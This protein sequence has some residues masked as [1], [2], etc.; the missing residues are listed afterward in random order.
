MGANNEARLALLVALLA[1]TSAASVAL[2]AYQ[3]SPQASTTTTTTTKITITNYN[4]APN[5]V[6]GGIGGGIGAIRLR[7]NKL[8]RHESCRESLPRRAEDLPVL[9]ITGRVK[10]VYMA[11]SP[12]LEG[13][14]NSANSSSS[15]LPPPTPQPADQQATFG[16]FFLVTQ[17]GQLGSALPPPSPVP[18][19]K[20]LVTVGRVLKGDQQ[21][22]NSD[23]IISGFNASTATPCPNFV[24]PND[25]YIMLLNQEAERLYSIQGAN[26]LNMNLNNLDRINS[27]AAN[28]P[29][30]I[31]GPIE[32]ILCEAHYC[33]YG[34]CVANESSGQASCQCP[35]ACPPWPMPVCG[36]DNTT[37]PNECH[38]I[39]EGCRRQKPLFVTKESSC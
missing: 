34:R 38:L 1:A 21:L 5:G 18:V 23:I 36:S 13:G 4:S 10:E 7:G 35:D 39:K 22:V 29:I 31:R 19:N 27:I 26:L 24:R 2:A 14:D 9:V 6:G 25:T 17:Y 3:S 8:R 15:N 28:E 30:K 33:P 20:A 32:D 37:Y 16:S 11:S 12:P